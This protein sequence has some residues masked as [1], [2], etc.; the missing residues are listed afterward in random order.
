MSNSHSFDGITEFVAVAETQGFSSAA[1][2][3]NVSTSHVSRQIAK[4]EKRLGVALFA[5]STRNVKLTDAGHRYYQHCQVLLDGIAHAN[6]EVGSQQVALSG[7]LR[8]SAAGEF[9]EQYI[10]PALI[11]FGALHPDLTIDMDFN[12]NMADFIQEGIDFSIRYG[13]LN[14]STLIARR[15]VDRKMLAAASPGYLAKHSRPQHPDE[16]KNHSCI[17][18]NNEHWRFTVEGKE[19]FVKVHPKWRSNSGRSLVKA[20]EAGLGICYMPR[21]SYGDSLQNKSLTPILEPYWSDK[22]TTWIVYANRQFLPLRARLA[23][24]F[25]VERFADWQE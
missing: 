5:R 18:S 24:E 11:E 17:I 14:D 25:L 22:A 2:K 6:E 8:V 12:S 16:L 3:L 19:H 9:A 4:V 15:L 20:A 13:R 23:I 21:S 1:R 7:T 10:V